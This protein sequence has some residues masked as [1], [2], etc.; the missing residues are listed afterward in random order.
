[1]QLEGSLP[2]PQ[3][4]DTSPHPDPVECR[5]SCPPYAFKMHLLSSTNLHRSQNTHLILEYVIC[6]LFSSFIK[7]SQT[8][9]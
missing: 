3:Q 9:T 7:Q 1:M 6:R 4:P 8:Q 2:W 5:M